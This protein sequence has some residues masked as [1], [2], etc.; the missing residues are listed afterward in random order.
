MPSILAY[1]IAIILLVITPGADTALILKVSLSQN[2]KKAFATIIG[3]GSGCIVWGIIVAFGLGQFLSNSPFIFNAIKMTGAVY[4]FWLGIKLWF[5][6][7]KNK[8]KINIIKAH[9]DYF[10]WFFK[11]FLTDLLNPKI[12]V[13]YITFLPQ[14][15]P[16]NCNITQYILFLVI[17]HILLGMIWSLILILATSY[18][19]K[20]F[21]LP[22]TQIWLDRIIGTIFFSFALKLVFSRK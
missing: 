9:S 7:Q 6:N 12:G 21:Q 1:L 17:L 11:G 19:S 22:K 14:F 10:Y 18:L 4:L 3:I 16:D 13:F 8:V 5:I 20:W 2:R 15:I